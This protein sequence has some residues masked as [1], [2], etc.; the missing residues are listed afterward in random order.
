MQDTARAIPESVFMVV[1]LIMPM[2]CNIVGSI[3]VGAV[4]VFGALYL[5]IDGG[6]K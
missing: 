2:C 4:C 6:Y 5:W 3:Q 1:L